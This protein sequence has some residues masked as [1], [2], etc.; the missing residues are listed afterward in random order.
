MGSNV[1]Q[2]VP[3]KKVGGVITPKVTG[4][5]L[6]FDNDVW[7]RE[8]NY[9]G[10]DVVNML[11]VNV[12]D[13]IDVGGTINLG[14]IEAA[15]DSGAIVLFDMPVS[16]TPAAGDEES[17]SIKIDGDNVLTVGAFADSAGGVTGHFI[18]SHGAQVVHKTDAGAADYNP[19]ILT[20]DYVITV[21]T[22]AAARA[23]VIST[24]DRDSGT[25]D[26]P[27]IF[28]IK[29]IAG[30]A[31]AQNITVSLETAGNIDGAG[32]AVINGNYNSI[33]LMVDGTNGY[34]I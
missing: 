6:E 14:S 28:I 13:E 25:P 11:K 5:L 2:F 29:D 15:E 33:T 19:G 22:T 20:S 23:V 1:Q 3:F 21:D 12:D 26:N 17:A 8:K 4:D 9:A 34:L 30:N 31:G 18:K 16:A 32:T 24:E 7:I 10:T 27:R